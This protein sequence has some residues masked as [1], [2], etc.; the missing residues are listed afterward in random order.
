MAQKKDFP[1][2]QRDAGLRELCR[3]L[4]PDSGHTKARQ[5]ETW[6]NRSIRLASG[7]GSVEGKLF[8]PENETVPGKA[9]EW[10][11]LDA[12]RICLLIYLA[13]HFGTISEVSV[14]RY[15][16]THLHGFKDDEAL[17]V[18]WSG[19]GPGPIPAGKNISV[20]ELDGKGSQGYRWAECIRARDLAKFQAAPHRRAVTAINLNRIEAEVTEAFKRLKARNNRERSQ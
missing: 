8:E 16:H 19:R 17:F 20:D 18:A 9:R 15:A 4:F 3:E 2:D 6:M 11:F 14:W 12:M 5:I 7:S 10:T 13:D 1:N